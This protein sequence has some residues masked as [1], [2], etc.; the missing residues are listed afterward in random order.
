MYFLL[1]RLTKLDPKWVDLFDVRHHTFYNQHHSPYYQL[2]TVAD[3]IVHLHVEGRRMSLLPGESFILKPWET[4][5][6]WHPED[7]N[8]KFFWVQFSCDPGMNEYEE[9]KGI[10]LNLV[11]VERTELRISENRHED[12]LILPRHFTPKHHYKLLGLFEELKETF[13]N[14]K[15]YFRFRATLLLGEMIWLMANDW[16]EQK[17]LDT[18]F[19]TS[20]LTFRRLV[21]HLNDNYMVE[22]NRDNLEQV[23][24]RKYE[25]L[26]Q[27][28][29]KYSSVNINQYIHQLRTQRAK[30]LLQN[31]A[32]T[33][34]AIAED[35]G[36]QDPFHF[37]RIFKKLTGISPQHY[38]SQ[39]DSFS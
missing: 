36:Y 27:V 10:D 38:R 34:K 1:P 15:G 5:G 32:K 25:Y 39:V 35:V 6:G 16:L 11:H 3:G 28:F 31:T 33:V 29:K 14:P 37:S 22:L 8:G 30:Y 13:K 2:I 4:H 26:C 21:E 19:P 17:Q 12:Q 23:L 24:D 20:Y 18:T 9:D 7:R